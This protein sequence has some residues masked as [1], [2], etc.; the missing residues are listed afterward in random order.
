MIAKTIVFFILL[1]LL[2]DGVLWF[3]YLRKRKW[4]AQLLWFIPGG[5]LLILTI[6][7]ALDRDFVPDDMTWLNIYLLLTG[8]VTCPKA[9]IALCSF[10]GKKGWKTGLVLTPIVWFVVLYGSFVGVRNLEVKRV[11][12]TFKDLPASFDGYRIVQFSDLHLGSV[13]SSLVQEVVDSINAQNADVVVFTGDIQNK[14]PQE[15]LG[16]KEV[17]STIK[18]KDGILSVRGN[19]DFAEYTGLPD[20]VKLYN[21]EQT[22]SYQQD[23]KWSFL[24]NGRRLIRRDKD[25]IV[26]AGLDN[27]GEGR[28]PAKG[29]IN[30]ALYG[31]SRDC[32]VVMLEHDPSAWRRKILRQCHAQLTLSGHTHGMQFR[33]F[34]FCPLRTFKKDVDGLSQVGD[35]YLYVSKGVGGV[36][37]FRF[38]TDPEIVVITLRRGK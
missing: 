17:L 30:Y 31:L 8:L 4:W 21:E 12:L 29:N 1:I 36:V 16:Y 34:G 6:L 32:F 5:L 33:L 20:M 18:G 35:R 10:C 25:S 11:E 23:M 22:I 7:L 19:H 15:I 28:F 13:P 26:I 14:L 38:G 24:L 9:L 37:P 27:D 3:R 2:P